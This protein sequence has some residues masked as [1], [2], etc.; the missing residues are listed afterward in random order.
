MVR[1]WLCAVQRSESAR[2]RERGGCGRAPRPLLLAPR[3]PAHLRAADWR[4]SPPVSSPALLAFR[5]RLSRTHRRVRR[6]PDG[7]SPGFAARARPAS[8]TPSRARARTPPS[9]EQRSRRQQH[10]LTES[11][12][13]ST[14]R[15]TDPLRR[16]DLPQA[17][18]GLLPSRCQ[19]RPPRPDALTDLV[20]LDAD[21]IVTERRRRCSRV[22]RRK[23]GGL[24]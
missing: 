10:L 6:G 22:E 3:S 1:L 11:T 16:V 12:A 19:P 8:S 21:R 17:D 23:G 4:V 13:S 24:E 15:R 20:V 14:S 2:R 7:R 9:H 5:L 18:F